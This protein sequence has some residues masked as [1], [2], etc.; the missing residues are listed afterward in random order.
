MTQGETT[1]VHEPRQ[2][3]FAISLLPWPCCIDGH[4]L[5]HKIPCLSKGYRGY[6]KFSFKTQNLGKAGA[7]VQQLV[8]QLNKGTC[9]FI[10]DS[11]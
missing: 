4:G 6:L 3:Q 9:P 5:S 11:L 7:D 1:L 10:F 8:H 2:D